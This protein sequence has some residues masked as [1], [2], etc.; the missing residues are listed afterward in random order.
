[1][2]DELDRRRFLRA[3]VAGMT[4]GVAGCGSGSN[5]PEYLPVVGG[6]E[7]SAQVPQRIDEYLRRAPA[8]PNYE[9]LLY[10]ADALQSDFV[11]IYVGQAEDAATHVFEP[12]AVMVPPDSTVRWNWIAGTGEHAVRSVESTVQTLDSGEPASDRDDYVVTFV[13]EGI[14]LYECPVHGAE[15]MKGA[16]VVTADPY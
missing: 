15:G 9:G 8:A 2:G 12:A 1:M 16:I 5:P 7:E 4:A 11:N 14:C 6:G 3:G 10:Q 13:E